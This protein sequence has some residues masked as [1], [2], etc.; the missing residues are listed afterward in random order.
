MRSNKAQLAVL[1]LITANFIWGAAPPIF[2]WALT[3]VHPYTLAFLRFAI[4]P[5]IMFPFVRHQ[6]KINKKD[7]INV[8]FAGLFGITVNIA[9]FFHGLLQAP[10]IN[11][12]LIAGSAPIFI[13]LYSLLFFKEKPKGKLIIGSLIGLMG[14]LV[15]LIVPLFKSGSIVAE[16]NVSYLIAMLGSV[17][18]MLINRKILKRNSPMAL[19]F[20]T[21]CVGGITFTPFFV[22]EVSRY[23]FL[24]QISMQ[25]IVGILFGVLLSSLAAYF[26]QNWALKYLTAADVSVFA[27]IDPV[28]TILVAAPLLHEFPN[29]VFV[30][31][32]FLV[33]GGIL[34]S[35]GRLH[36]HPFQLFLRP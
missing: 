23:G 19:T 12:A 20:W 14:V 22:Q 16:G 36:Y 24:Q 13:I 18:G 31:G 1:A 11:A 33:L 7:Y 15:V 17:I 10:S 2:K 29:G 28:V 9:F 8:L 27:Y 34:L 6:L 5:L 4:P 32:S 3:D 26:L 35:E 21:F 30:I 25:G